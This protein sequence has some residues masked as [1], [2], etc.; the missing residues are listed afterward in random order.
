LLAGG[1]PEEARPYF[2]SG[3]HDHVLA[4]DDRY[5]M[6]ARYDGAEAKLFDLENDPKMDKNISSAN[7]GVAKKM[8]TDYVLKDAG[9]PLP[10][11]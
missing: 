6:F 2:T 4:R 1:G 11:Y 8:F 5:A 10:S 9:G 7:P 3:Y